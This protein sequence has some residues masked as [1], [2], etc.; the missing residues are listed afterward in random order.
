[1][2]I[3]GASGKGDSI[4]VGHLMWQVNLALLPGF[5]VLLYFYGAGYLQNLL[6]A[7]IA[8][9]GFEALAL[10]LRG[11]AWQ[12]TSFDGS[13]VLTCALIA[14]A[15]PPALS[16]V[17]LLSAVAAAVLLAKHAF[18]GIGRNL[19][20]PAMVGYAVALVSFPAAFALWPVPAD[21]VTSA[22][23]LEALKSL[24][25]LTYEELHKADYG[26]GQY[27]GYGLEQAGLA[28][29]LGGAYLIWKRLAA[30]RVSLGFLLTLGACAIAGYDNGSSTTGGSPGQ[31]LLSGGTL[32]AA[33]FV[34]TDPVTH[35]SR[36]AAQWWFGA[37]AALLTYAIRTVG[38]Y[39]DGIAFAVLLANATSP[40]L[41]RIAASREEI[42]E[43]RRQAK[44]S[45]N[46]SDNGPNPS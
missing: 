22:T 6:I 3:T 21:G 19:F 33:F 13:V 37:L 44:R 18:G 7:V 1:M 25:G 17:A 23:A 2:V 12:Q 9:V 24:E 20:N 32:I 41:N 28:F 4:G 43:Q 29:A 30:W 39:P 11:R 45:A 26:F 36:Y 14:L 16:I 8:G 15:A 27:G 10:V 31:H 38:A 42:R 5:A 40:V 34:L 35:P 46:P